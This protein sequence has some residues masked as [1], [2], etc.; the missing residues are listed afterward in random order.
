M[1][2]PQQRTVLLV[3]DDREIL[4][5]LRLRMSVAGHR[6]LTAINGQEG[7][8]VALAEHP[9]L[10]VLDIR[11]PVM[12]GLTALT[13]LRQ[14]QATANIPAIMVTASLIDK[15]RAL[16]LGARYFLEKPFDARRLGTLVASALNQPT[17]TEE[18]NHGSSRP[19]VARC[20]RGLVR[21]E[22]SAGIVH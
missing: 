12:D 11:M 3:D 17:E 1:T 7:V 5:G 14:C 19:Q 4:A 2:I 13:Q 22:E 8:R 16:D 18:Q 10:I 9:D 15:K 21:G 6:V 20:D